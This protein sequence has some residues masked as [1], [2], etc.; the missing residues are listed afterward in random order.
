MMLPRRPIVDVS[1]DCVVG[2]MFAND[3]ETLVRDNWVKSCCSVARV[4]ALAA[5]EDD[6]DDMDDEPAW[7]GD[8]RF[9]A[10]LVEAF[11]V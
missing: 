4:L 1:S 7:C 11:G 2:F 3:P 5:D 6:D 10:R 9:G 8:I